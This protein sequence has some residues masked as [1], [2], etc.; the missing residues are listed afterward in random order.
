MQNDLKVMTF[1]EWC[2]LNAI[3]VATGKRLIESGNGPK[4]IQ[5]SVKR[6]GIRACDNAAWQESRA[7]T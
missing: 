5:L 1:R 4:V 6:I 2:D 7:R 3:S